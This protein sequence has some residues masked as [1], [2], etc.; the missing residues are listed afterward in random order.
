MVDQSNLFRVG[1][2]IN[3]HGIRGELKVSVVTDFPEQRFQENSDL[4]LFDGLD[5]QEKLKVKKARPNKNNWIISFANLADI[6]LV[7]KYK[8]F[9]LYAQ[10][11]DQLE[12]EE[13]Q[14]LYQQLINLK[15]VDTNKGEIGKIVEIMEMPANDVWVV[16]QGSY[17]EILLPVIDQVIKNVDLDNRIVQ[18]EL[19]EGLIDEN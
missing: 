14:Y 12:V 10:G 16:D 15:V 17:G 13:G 7:E 2:I 4:Y 8:N 3:T 11:I 9:D 6:N 5:F 19:L 18:V 1:K